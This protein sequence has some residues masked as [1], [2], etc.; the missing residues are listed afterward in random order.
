MNFELLRNAFMSASPSESELKNLGLSNEDSRELIGSFMI[1]H[2]KNVDVAGDKN[3]VASTF[4][5]L[6]DPSML[7]VG[8][9]RFSASPIKNDNGLIVGQVEA[10]PLIIDSSTGQVYVDDLTTP[11]RRLWVCSDNFEH[12]LSALI[13]AAMYL[14]RCLADGSVRSDKNLL[15]NSLR[16]CIASAGGDEYAAFYSMLLGVE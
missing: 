3:D 12:F 8:M 5:R 2:R 10:D 4:F 13:P 11:G 1:E 9:V 7:E 6:F 15:A 14:G 16:E